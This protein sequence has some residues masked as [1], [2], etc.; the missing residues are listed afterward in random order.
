MTREKLFTNLAFAALAATLLAGCGCGSGGGDTAKKDTGGDSA[1]SAGGSSGTGATGSG[2]AVATGRPTPTAEGPKVTGNTIKIAVIGSI[3]GDQKPWGEDSFDG[4]QMAVDEVNKAGGIQGKKIELLKEDAGSKAEVA[5]TAAEKALSDGAIGI[6]GDVSSGNT[7]VIAKSAFAKAVPVIAIG[8]T[9]VTLTDQGSNVFRVCYTDDVQ[10]PV[11]A[12]FAYDKLNLRKM[13]VL[14]D[15]KQ[16][17]S[18]GLSKSFIDAFNKDGGDIVAEEKYE[19]GQT[20]FSSQLTELA[21][22]QPDGVFISG[23]FTEVGPIVQQAKAAGIKGP[24]LGGDG[25]DSP[26]LLTSG[27]D[28]VQGAYFCNHY[29]NKENR[30]IV[31]EFLKKYEALHSGHLP[32][33]T[34]AA[35]GYDA[36]SLMLDALKRSKGLDSKDL[37]DAIA[38]TTDFHGVTGDITLKGMNGNPPKRALVV[39]VTPMD[40]QGQWQ[41][42]AIAYTPDQVK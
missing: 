17:Y 2:D 11:M 32:G 3:T 7:I 31:G 34:M 27:G 10:G 30:P 35:L 24:F 33:T 37:T 14:T 26:Q 6:C 19:S 25:W 12:K 22:K 4:A 9:K 38:D 40:A 28:A 29:N 18:Q 15:N 42:F 13:G 41:K 39:Q 1:T 16:P 21:A 20:Q 8:A 5:Q 36:V 23:Y